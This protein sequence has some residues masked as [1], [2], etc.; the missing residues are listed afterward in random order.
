L[1]GA[2]G[3]LLGLLLGVVVPVGEIDPLG[4]IAEWVVRRRLVRHDVHFD[5]AAKEFGEDRRGVADESDAACDVRSLG[6]FDARER[7]VE[8]GRPLVEVAL[9][10]SS[11][12]P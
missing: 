5:A 7:L 6:P 2:V 11:L 1:T 12:Q 10:D 4:Q 9:V 3:E 8:V